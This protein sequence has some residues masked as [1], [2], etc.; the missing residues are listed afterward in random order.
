M[1]VDF[2]TDGEKVVVRLAGDIDLANAGTVHNEVNAAI[3]NRVN[4]VVVDLSE[5]TYLDSAGLSILFAL[6]R[7]LQTLQTELEV[8]VPVDSPVRRAVE[9]SGL[10]PAARLRAE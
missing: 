9:L 1:T 2:Q 6:A 4:T 3:T 5:V 7:R 10:E 8:L